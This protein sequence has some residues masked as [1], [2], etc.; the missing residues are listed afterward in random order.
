MFGA[1]EIHSFL[2]RTMGEP[3]SLFYVLASRRDGRLG[4]FRQSRSVFATV[5]TKRRGDAESRKAVGRDEN[6]S[7]LDDRPEAECHATRKRRQTQRRLQPFRRV[8]VNF[9]QLQARFEEEE[10]E[11]MKEDDID[12]E[13]VYF[14]ANAVVCWKC[15]RPPSLSLSLSM[16]LSAS[17]LTA[18]DGVIL[19]DAAPFRGRLPHYE[20]EDFNQ[21]VACSPVLVFF[22]QFKVYMLTLTS[23][24]QQKCPASQ[25]R[26]PTAVKI[27]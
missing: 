21:R 18:I 9:Q 3:S 14:S 17:C 12:S 20:L 5:A 1:N 27:K 2:I 6:A 22:P 8:P 11:T 26:A 16:G 13:N 15:R 7:S 10:E 24:S 25:Q 4:C 23:N 19:N